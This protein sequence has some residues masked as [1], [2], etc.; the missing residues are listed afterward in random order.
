MDYSYIMD[1]KIDYGKRKSKQDKK[2]KRKYRV[3]KLGGKFRIK[4][5]L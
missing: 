4:K 3:Y 1:E 2:A 5:P